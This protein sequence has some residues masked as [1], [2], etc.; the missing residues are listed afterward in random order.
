MKTFDKQQRHKHHDE[1]GIE[2]ISKHR[3][4]Q[5]RF[6]YCE[7]RPFAQMSFLNRSQMTKEDFLHGEAKEDREEDAHVRQNHEACIAL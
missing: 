2:L 3:H 5:E 4:G 7:P 6:R 1:S